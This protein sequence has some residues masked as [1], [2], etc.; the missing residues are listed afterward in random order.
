MAT[1]I[2]TR[3]PEGRHILRQYKKKL[4]RLAART[5]PKQLGMNSGAREG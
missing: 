2:R 3:N 4:K 5:T 1:D